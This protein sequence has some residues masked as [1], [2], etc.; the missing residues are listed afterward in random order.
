M[1]VCHRPRVLIVDDSDV[2]V[3][4]CQRLLD[5]DG[6]ECVTSATGHHAFDL[7]VA[8]APDVV[9][10]DL[11]LPGVDG[12]AIC[13]ALK[14]APETR[15]V[16]VLTMTGHPDWQLGALEAGAD[17]VLAKPLAAAELRARVRSAV[18]LK[19]NLDDLDNA[20]A[21]IVMLG[22]TIEARD[23][24]TDGHCRR[25]SVYA[26]DL[27][28]SLGLPFDE[29]RAL[30]RGGYLHDVGKVAIPDA[31]LYKPGPLTRAEFDV[32]KTHPMVGD[33]LCSPL[34]SLERERTII[35]SHHELL[36][37][38]GYPDGLR[39]S[40]VPLLAQITAIVDVYDALTT[41]RPYRAALS[42][43][44]AFEILEGE[45]LAGKRDREMV[46]RFI[47]VLGAMGHDVFDGEPTTP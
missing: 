11:Q 8:S 26:S 34:R 40:A 44:R 19:R 20:A 18:R 22:A 9:L 46:D 32:I 28:R 47:G 35:R 1:I 45:C 27:G 15:L 24:S 29:V 6:Y 37:G 42:P 30:E 17:D 12:L 31:V 43:S 33:R 38:S 5:Q 4:F 13:R 36:D 23:R 7:C 21:S 39:G 25:L 3:R 10:L 16:P 2:Q 41:N 14:S